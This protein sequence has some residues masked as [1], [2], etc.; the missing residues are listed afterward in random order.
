MDS[1]K[2]NDETITVL[3]SEVSDGQSSNSSVLEP[4]PAKNGKAYKEIVEWIKALAIAVLLVFVI[5]TFLFSPFIVEGPSMK[6]NFE[7]GERLIVNKILFEIRQ[8]KHGEV[9][10]FHVPDQGRD[11]IKR[12][13]ALPGETIRVEGDDVYVNEEK[14]E[15]PYIKKAVQAAHDSGQL[16]NTGSNLP[17]GK[18]TETVV[19]EGT[20]FAM[21]DNRGDS[22]D[23]RDIGYI[24]KDELIGRADVIFWPLDKLSIIKH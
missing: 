16:Y 22:Q 4:A 9:V 6:P 18:V 12:V 8:P 17:N 1:Q 23:S 21:G 5:R 10:V 13:I 3:N 14:I 7:T 20:I 15:E 19:P 2:Q 11:F 24:N